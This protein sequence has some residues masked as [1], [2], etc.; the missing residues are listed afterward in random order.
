MQIAYIYLSHPNAAVDSILDK[1]SQT[2]PDAQKRWVFPPWLIGTADSISTLNAQIKS[3]ASL[4]LE[5]QRP[6]AVERKRLTFPN[7]A[8]L[9][10]RAVDPNLIIC[11]RV[12][13]P[14]V[15]SKEWTAIR[16]SSEPLV[17]PDEFR[18]LAFIADDES[19][20]CTF[21]FPPARRSILPPLFDRGH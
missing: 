5:S 7:V 2:I 19:T 12:W 15:P 9:V 18:P 10:A 1:M 20:P 17:L 16:L 8:I 4:L 14:E 11:V 3:G 6:S 13:N 21:Q